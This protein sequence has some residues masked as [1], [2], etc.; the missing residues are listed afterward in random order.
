MSPMIALDLTILNDGATKLGYLK[1]DFLSPLVLNDVLTTAAEQ[2][3]QISMP[4]EFWLS[5]DA[6]K[7]FMVVRSTA[8]DIR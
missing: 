8:S 1:S 4:V 5:A 2:L 7:T 3:G 6:K